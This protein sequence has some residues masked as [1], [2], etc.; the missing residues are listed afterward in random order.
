M[1]LG[2][3]SSLA[4]FIENLICNNIILLTKRESKPNKEIEKNVD[5][6]SGEDSNGLGS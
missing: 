4:R 5:L 6:L 3:M 1:N 2:T